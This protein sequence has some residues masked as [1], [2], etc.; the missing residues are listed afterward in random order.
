MWINLNFAEWETDRERVKSTRIKNGLNQP[1][2]NTNGLNQPE[3]RVES[4]PNYSNSNYI[5]SLRS[6][7]FPVPFL[8][9]PQKF[10]KPEANSK[11]KK[12]TKK[13]AKQAIGKVAIAEL[14]ELWA[15]HFPEKIQ[16]RQFHKSKERMAKAQRAWEA[17][18][19]LERKN[20]DPSYSMVGGDGVVTRE[21]AI[22][23]WRK[24][25]EVCQQREFLTH[26]DSDWFKLD[27]LLKFENVMKIRE[28]D[29]KTV[30]G[31]KN[32][33]Y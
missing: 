2:K 20:G 11:P 19:E 23:F 27:W 22:E 17:C 24:V 4:T 33:G 6:Y 32:A 10:E 14:L 13:A 16:P 30:R 8:K 3:K 9:A 15:E 1:D 25:M 18:L 28:G 12:Q 5:Y 21:G 31:N 7:M 29:F 26:P